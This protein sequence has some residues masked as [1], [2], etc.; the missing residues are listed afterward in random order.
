MSDWLAI[1]SDA[2]THFSTGCDMN[3]PGGPYLTTYMT[4]KDG[5]Y[6]SK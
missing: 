5:S 3:M 1:N 2:P 4:G 6:W